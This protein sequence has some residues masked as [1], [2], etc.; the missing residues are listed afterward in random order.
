MPK[1]HYRAVNGTGKIVRGKRVANDEQDLYE[2]LRA[3]DLYL[4][5]AGEEI[6][7][8]AHRP[9]SAN[10]LADFCRELGTLLGAGVPLVRALAII[11]QE[12]GIRSWERAV[13]LELLRLVR[14]GTALSDAMEEQENVFPELMISMFR[15]AEESGNM[16]RAAMELS[17]QFVKMYQLQVKV[18]NSIAYPEFLCVL[19]A[20]VTVVLTGYVL[21]QFEPLFSFMEEL[22]L[23]TRILYAVTGFVNAYWPVILCGLAGAGMGWKL[24]CMISA[25]RIWLDRQKLHIPVV[26][27]LMKVIYTARFAR[28]LSSLYASGIPLV[29]GMQIA[30]KTIGNCW[31][32]R[33]FDGAIAAVRSGASFSDAIGEIDGFVRKL[34]AAAYVG[35]EAGSLDVMLESIAASMEYEAEMAVG[36]LVSYVEPALILVMAVIVGGI[37]LAVM[38]PIYASY[39]AIEMSVY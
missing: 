33:Q 29:T 30:R 16:D 15:F 10:R 4:L 36:K 34:S 24:L 37:M 32:E 5:R 20:A 9:I 38:M 28:A 17:A 21:P 2:K 12:E 18:K 31:I 13:Y 25:V 35:E 8:K 27:R 22:P 23:P 11:A 6:K 26:G 14:Q 7:R 1:Y 19:I 39:T 3:D